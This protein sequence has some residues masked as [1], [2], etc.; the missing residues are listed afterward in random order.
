[1]WPFCINKLW[2]E[3]VVKIVDKWN[4][5]LKVHAMHYANEL[6]VC[7]RFSFSTNSQHTDTIQKNVWEKSDGAY[8]FLIRVQTMLHHISVCFL[9][10]YQHQRKCF[11]QS[12]SWKRHCATHWHKQWYNWLV[13]QIFYC[14][15]NSTILLYIC[16]VIWTQYSLQLDNNYMYSSMAGPYTFS[17]GD[18]SGFS[19]YLRGG[20]ATQVKMPKIVKFVSTWI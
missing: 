14:T 5:H 15:N 9:P 11:F 12:A 20:I 3:L 7:V 18:T 1:M 6:F 2:C 17:I 10:Q 16:T 4:S 13:K 19:D 8:S